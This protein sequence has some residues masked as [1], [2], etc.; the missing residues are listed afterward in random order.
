MLDVKTAFEIETFPV[1][2]VFDKEKLVLKTNELEAAASFI[3][4]QHHKTEKNKGVNPMEEIQ[5]ELL[6]KERLKSDFTKLGVTR[7]MTV[8]MHS[9]MKAIGGFVV[10]GA[11]AVVLAIEECIGN[12]GTLVMPTHTSDLSDPANWRYPLLINRGGTRLERRCPHL[13]LILLLAII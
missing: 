10:G 7:E 3:S 8:I 6:T 2:L 5:G 11:A 1:I 4:S 12:Q 13:L 9:S